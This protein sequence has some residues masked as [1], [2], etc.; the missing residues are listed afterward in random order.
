MKNLKRALSFALATVMLIGMMVVGVS[1]ASFGD[2]DE[3][4]NTDA[5]NTMVALGII[6]GKDNG[7]FDPE[8]IVTRAEMA[9]M[10]CV[11]LNGG[12][13]PNL[14]GGGL[15]ADTKGHWAAG[16]I[17]YCT[18]MGIVSGDTAG[19]FNP[20][21][22][23]TGTEAAK[24]I[25]IA[26]G[27]S[28][29]NEKFVN[30]AN[31]ALNINIV[32][33][34]KDLYKDLAILPSEGLTRDNAAQMLWNG[35]DASMVEYDYKLTTENGEL[36]TVAIAKDKLVGNPA[37]TVTILSEKFNMD[38]DYG[39]MTAVSYTKA[40]NEYNYTFDNGTTYTGSTVIAAGDL[41][42]SATSTEDYS[43]LFGMK[44]KIL[45]KTVNSKTTIYGMYAVDSEVLTSGL[46]GEIENL[47]TGSTLKELEFDGTKFQLTRAANATP[48]HYYNVGTA[49]DTLDDADALEASY[50][51]ELIDNTGDGKGDVVIAHPYKA[52]K[53]TF[54]NATSF[55]V[56]ASVDSATS[57]KYEDVETAGETFK[58]G[59]ILIATEKPHTPKTTTT[60]FAKAEAVEGK[61]EG[62]KTSK[63]MV[64]GEWYTAAATQVTG[65]EAIALGDTVKLAVVNGYYVFAEKITSTTKDILL[66]A[67]ADATKGLDGNFNAKVVF[68]DG[69][70]EIVKVDETVTAGELYIYELDDG[71]YDVTA[72]T[73]S[74]TG[75]DAAI[76]GINYD[77]DQS[78]AVLS[79]GTTRINADTVVFV[80]Y[81]HETSSNTGATTV[82]TGVNKLTKFAVINGEELNKWNFDFGAT[83]STKGFADTVNGFTTAKVLFLA[84]DLQTLGSTG[85]SNYGYIVSDPY[86]GQEGTTK[87][88]YFDMWNGTENVSVKEKASSFSY[89]KGDVISYTDEGNGIV[90]DVTAF[91]A[92]T[93]LGAVVAYDGKTINVEIDKAADG[94]N[95]IHAAKDI[96]DKTQFLYINSAD[97][98]GVAGGEVAMAEELS[99]AGTYNAN[100]WVKMTNTNDVDVLV[101]DVNNKVVDGSGNAT[102]IDGRTVSLTGLDSVSGDTIWDT[103]VSA[104]DSN[105]NALNAAT[106]YVKDGETITVTVKTTS[107]GSKGFEV[108]V[109]STKVAEVA[110]ATFAANAEKTVTFTASA[111][112]TGAVT[113]VDKA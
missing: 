72:A 94:T 52:V 32:A 64:G 20:D 9:K 86:L 82:T 18:N 21:K 49:A 77:K 56:N 90:D 65:S 92:A 91:T 63:V 74:N 58:K 99:T 39:Y 111:S 79:D 57:F 40:K 17:D 83:G 16:Y 35:M 87:Y 30:D 3:I 88:V 42:T 12:K 19:N 46:L 100:V 81:K 53:V 97:V 55:T 104:T 66:V 108:K 102:V 26:L 80:A 45:S 110:N 36:K 113:L 106:V 13:D 112:V 107:G 89:A 61:I 47:T 109:G 76:S 29:E 27:Y 4:V 38:T 33:N 6:K 34:S 8:G 7:N 31:W 10:I 15:Y 70:T 54:T 43:D 95:D 85:D 37:H 98:A 62:T 2:A 48:I 1:A 23:V 71:V 73:T 101:I 78:K 105:G 5:V 50:A 44:V 68:P 41:K 22:T 67:D 84:A 14:A 28:A 96:T 75:Y 59:D 103:F 24:M 51:Y 11:A 69:T 93:D 60:I 25:L